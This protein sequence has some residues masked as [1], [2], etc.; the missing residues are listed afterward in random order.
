MASIKKGFT[1]IDIRLLKMF[2]MYLKSQKITELPDYRVVLN[3][4]SK[5]FKP[6]YTR[7][8]LRSLLLKF[9]NSDCTKYLYLMKL[10]KQTP[11]NEIYNIIDEYTERQDLV[12]IKHRWYNEIAPFLMSSRQKIRNTFV[13]IDKDPEDTN[14]A[15]SLEYLLDISRDIRID[16]NSVKEYL[17]KSHVNTKH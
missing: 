15:L 7:T 1:L 5:K 8:Q 12:Y 14:F 17:K 2:D 13:N 9:K 4:F 3:Q 16:V 10:V 6:F 11:E